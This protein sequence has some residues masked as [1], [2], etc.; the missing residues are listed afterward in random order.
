VGHLDVRRPQPPG[1]AP[2]VPEH[3]APAPSRARAVVRDYCKSAGIPYT[4]TSVWRSYA[5]VIDYLNRV[6]LAARDPFDCPMV[7]GY[8]RA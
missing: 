4:E 5:I 3:G 8:R 6:G 7:A 1:R 2:P